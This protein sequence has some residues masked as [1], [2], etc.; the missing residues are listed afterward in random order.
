MSAEQ[1]RPAWEFGEGLGLTPCSITCKKVAAA[2]PAAEQLWV[3]WTVGS[4]G[5]R[6]SAPVTI[7]SSNYVVVTVCQVLFLALHTN[8]LF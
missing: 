4:V 5:S 6:P 1:F 2:P 3:A 7:K 8:K